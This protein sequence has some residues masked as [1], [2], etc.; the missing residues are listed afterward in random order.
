MFTTNRLLIIILA[1]GLSSCASKYN[2]TNSKWRAVKF[3]IDSSNY[4][5]E[6]DR[7]VYSGFDTSTKL[8]QEFSDTLVFTF[9]EGAP[10]DTSIYRV[11]DDTLFYIQGSLRDTS[12]IRKLSKD[13]LIEQRLGGVKTYSIRVND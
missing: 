10:V 8:Y 4:L 2:L 6:L 5:S 1:L 9:V 3:A 11:K 13:S 7:S 12:L